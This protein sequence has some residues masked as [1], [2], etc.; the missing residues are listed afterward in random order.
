MRV[1]HSNSEYSLR[2]T[3][4]IEDERSEWSLLDKNKSIISASKWKDLVDVIYKTTYRTTQREID[5]FGL[6]GGGYMV[7]R[8]RPQAEKY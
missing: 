8:R 6:D 1:E 3:R 5:R 4:L 2:H 7:Q